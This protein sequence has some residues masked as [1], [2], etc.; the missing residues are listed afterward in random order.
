M[1]NFRFALLA[2]T[3]VFVLLSACKKDPVKNPATPGIASIVTK[4]VSD[5]GENS[6]K[7]GIEFTVQ[8][9]LS[10]IES[11]LCLSTVN[12]P[13]IA[14]KHSSVS[15]GL[16][17]IS[18]A[19]KSFVLDLNG[20][21][22]GTTYYVRAYIELADTI[23]YGDVVSF[24]TKEA[25]SS[26]LEYTDLADSTVRLTGFTMSRYE[27]E[28]Y[29]DVVVP[30][31][32]PVD[33]RVVIVTSGELNVPYTYKTVIKDMGALAADEAN[34]SVVLGIPN[35]LF[36]ANA[37]GRLETSIVNGKTVIRFNSVPMALYLDPTKTSDVTGQFIVE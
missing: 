37:D 31:V 9:E 3:S 1:K 33:V 11:G 22:A 35:I 6:A 34:L 5:I 36:P 27:N 13:T 17:T 16:G 25:L 29:F 30:D 20:L 4:A 23:L 7:S 24:V 10:V 15:T 26:F 28:I 14:D 8:G 21:S 19:S 18:N 32:L 12:D 2:I